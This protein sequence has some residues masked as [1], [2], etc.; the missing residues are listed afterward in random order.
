MHRILIPAIGAFVTVLGIGLGLSYGLLELAKA[1]PECVDFAMIYCGLVILP[2]AGVVAIVAEIACAWYLLRQQGVL[3]PLAIPILATV[4]SI[5]FC[6][7]PLRILSDMT[8][9]YFAFGLVLIMS[10][11]FFDRYI[12]RSPGRFDSKMLRSII[13]FGI[14]AIAGVLVHSFVLV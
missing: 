2:L 3:H 11:I 7:I 1:S 10:F 6:Y 9:F 4:G 8:L 13:G 5:V 14:V 12:N